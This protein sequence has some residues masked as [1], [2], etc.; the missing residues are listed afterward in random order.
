M[1]L[2]W[3]RTFI[4][5]AEESHFQRAAE[6]L[7]IAQPTVSLHIRKLED[8]WGL[9]LFDR[10]GRNV[11]ISGAGKRALEYAKKMYQAY[12]ESR[13]EMARWRQGFEE[14]LVV[15][16][17]PIVGQTF[18]S[19]WIRLMNGR[20]PGVQ[21]RLR[22]VDSDQVAHLVEGGEA[23]I[24]FSRIHPLTRRLQVEALYLD[25]LVMI[26][27]AGETDHDGPSLSMSEALDAYPLITHNHPG[28]WDDL[29]PLIRH[30]YPVLRTMQVSHTSVSLHFVEQGFATS[31]LPKSLIRQSIAMGRIMEISTEEIVLPMTYTYMMTTTAPQKPATETFQSLVKAYVLDRLPTARLEMQNRR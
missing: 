23:D 30:C 25:P 1:E 2:D 5:A 14:T 3:I 28:F 12:E 4:V 26:G 16:A 24:G 15:A 27:P 22:V 20:R 8:A 6:R 29:V 31:I 21:I 13:E 17:S 19:S 10:S 7:H 18:L 11:K 9:S